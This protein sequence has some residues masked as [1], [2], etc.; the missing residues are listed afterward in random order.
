MGHYWPSVSSPFVSEVVESADLLI[1][2]GPIMNDYNTTGWTAL[3]PVNKRIEIQPTHV[4]VC[5][6]VYNGVLMHE[7]LTELA[8]DVPSRPHSLQTYKR[9]SSGRTITE[10]VAP[11][12]TSAPLTLDEIRRQVQMQ[13]RADTELVVETGD[14]WFIGQDFK[15]PDGLNYHV[16]MQ[17][18]SIGWS[19]GAVLGAALAAEDQKRQVLALIGDGSLQVTAQ[20][21]STIIRQGVKATIILLNN[22]GYTIEVEIHD[23]PYNDIQNWD[24]AELINVFNGMSARSKV[25]VTKSD[26]DPSQLLKEGCGKKLPSQLVPGLGIRVTTSSELTDALRTADAHN[27]LTLIECVIARDDCTS[28]LLLW[29]AKVAAANARPLII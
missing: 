6:C 1:F 5:G 12:D 18:G 15:I 24:Y 16:Q 4:R 21:L 14:S 29:G 19:V 8:R 17:Y 27:G 7:L 25:P 11:E 26:D 9:L 2:V 23:G 10:R 13:L 22:N 28:E 20:E 3:L